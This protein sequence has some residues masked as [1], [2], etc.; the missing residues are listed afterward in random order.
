VSKLF[1]G[2]DVSQKLVAACF[3]LDD[4]T[5][6]IKRFGFEH[7]PAGVETLVDRINTTLL[8]YRF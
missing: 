1:V 3:L 2:L 8:G 7:N 5:E 6:P 4:G